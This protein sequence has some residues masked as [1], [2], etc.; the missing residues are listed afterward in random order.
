MCEIGQSQSYRVRSGKENVTMRHFFFLLFL[1]SVSRSSLI[2]FNMA[3]AMK[4]HFS[5]LVLHVEKMDLTV[6]GDTYMLMVTVVVVIF[7]MLFIFL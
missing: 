5:K 7:V 4:V 3:G 2:T 1:S 6:F